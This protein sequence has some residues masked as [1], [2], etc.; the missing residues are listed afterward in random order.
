MRHHRRARTFTKLSAAIFVALAAA[1]CGVFSG[2][3]P[4][5][6][7]PGFRADSVRRPAV[8]V[9]VSISQD[10]EEREWNRIGSE[11]QGAVEEALNRLGLLPVDTTFAAGAGQ[12][13]LEGLDR[14]RPLARARETG[15]EHLLIVDARLAR[16][17]VT[18][19]PE[20]KQPRS[21]TAAFWE[22]GLEIRRASNGQPLL[23][24]PGEGRAVEVDVDC[25][26][27]QVTRRKSM[28]VMIEESV[29]AVLAPFG[30]R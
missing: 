25:R 1:A 10:F 27:G 9:R 28:D 8:F 4:A 20:S 3:P 13:P 18:L 5:Q 29:D 2:P 19:C 16:G 23:V 24:K 17:R 26:T 15:A 12:H 21:G 7:E 22:A 11:Y 30:P 6:R 14:A